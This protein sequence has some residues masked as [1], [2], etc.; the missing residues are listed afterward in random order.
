M[1]HGQKNIKIPH[2]VSKT[3]CFWTAF[4]TLCGKFM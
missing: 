4:E 1:M 2:N 3:A